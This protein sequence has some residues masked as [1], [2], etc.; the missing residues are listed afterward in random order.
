MYLLSLYTR[1]VH[2]S[3]GSWFI[4]KPSQKSVMASW[5]AGMGTDLILAVNKGLEALGGIRKYVPA[6]SSVGILINAPSWWNKPGSY[7]HPEIVLAVVLASLE[8]GAKEIHYLIDP[9]RDFWKRTPLA[10]KHEK[11]IG[12]I[13]TC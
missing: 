3:A 9:A 1:Y 4:Q 10:A 6:G 8:A 12:G 13:K 5:A 11:E 7:T 2:V